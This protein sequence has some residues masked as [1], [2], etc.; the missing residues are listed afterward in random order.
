MLLSDNLDFGEDYRFEKGMDT[1]LRRYREE[2]FYNPVSVGD[3]NHNRG[4]DIL[5]RNY[6]A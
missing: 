6:D 4:N 1:G 2:I 3:F 5:I